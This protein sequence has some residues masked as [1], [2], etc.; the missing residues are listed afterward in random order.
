MFAAARFFTAVIV[1]WTASLHWPS[2]DYYKVLRAVVFVVTGYGAYT[3]FRLKD[4]AWLWTFALIAILFNPIIIIHLTRAIWLPINLV[5]GIALLIS[6]DPK[7][8][9]VSLPDPKAEKAT[10]DA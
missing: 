6:L 1:I 7:I 10:G 3:A 5:T 9:A 2:Y 4:K 8:F